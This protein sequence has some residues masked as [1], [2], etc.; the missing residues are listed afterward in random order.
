MPIKN[1]AINYRYTDVMNNGNIV[2]SSQLDWGGK[3]AV[4]TKTLE[5]SGSGSQT[6]SIDAYELQW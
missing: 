3:S 1:Y 5:F 2:S 6:I 4:A